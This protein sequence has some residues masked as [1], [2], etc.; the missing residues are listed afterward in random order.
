M[1]KQNL[2]YEAPVVDVVHLKFR[3]SVMQTSPQSYEYGNSGENST[4]GQDLG[5]GDY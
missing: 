4:D 1:K 2:T 5:D 3:N